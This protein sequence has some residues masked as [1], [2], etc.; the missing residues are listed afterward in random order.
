[1]PVYHV[2]AM[3][4][5]HQGATALRTI[6]SAPPLRWTD[7]R[8]HEQTLWGLNGSA[9]RRDGTVTLTVTNPHPDEPRDTEIAVRGAAVR[10]VT[11]TTLAGRDI[12]DHNT[13]ENP[14]AVVPAVE[15]AR[16]ASSPFTYRFPP[17]SVT[18]LSLELGS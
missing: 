15:A 4:A 17:A 8:Q 3:Y 5:P 1:T 12:H 16:A 13:F 10:S 2:F 6:A 7:E 9:S 11:A 18:R 14:D